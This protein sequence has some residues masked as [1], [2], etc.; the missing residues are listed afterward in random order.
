MGKEGKKREID[1]KKSERAVPEMLTSP[2]AARNL[3]GW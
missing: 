1:R 2:V 3:A